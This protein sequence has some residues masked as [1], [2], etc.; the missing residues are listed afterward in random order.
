MLQ[1]VWSCREGSDGLAKALLSSLKLFLDGFVHLGSEQ[2][3]YTGQILD[4]QI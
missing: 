1:G 2:G 3:F 4:W